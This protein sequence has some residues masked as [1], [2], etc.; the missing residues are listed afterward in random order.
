MVETMD[1]FGHVFLE[2]SYLPM[3]ET[4]ITQNYSKPVLQS[5]IYTRQDYISDTSHVGFA[6][7]NSFH[8][9]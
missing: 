7:K 5:N 2:Y 4:D 3:I 1:C 6:I 9:F 8:F